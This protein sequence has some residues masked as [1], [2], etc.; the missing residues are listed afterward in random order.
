[1]SICPRLGGPLVYA[2]IVEDYL[3][4]VLGDGTSQLETWSPSNEALVS[5][6]EVGV[7]KNR[8]EDMQHNI[9][10]CHVSTLSSV[11][12]SSTGPSINGTTDT[13]AT[14]SCP[15]NLP[16]SHPSGDGHDLEHFS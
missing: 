12:N 16:N 13:T 8:P 5:T 9:Y 2:A 11:C 7:Q 4:R 6:S 3:P 10:T 15:Q 1:M 14:C